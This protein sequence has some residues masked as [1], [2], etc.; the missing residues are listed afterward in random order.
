MFWTILIALNF[1]FSKIYADCIN[2]ES[3]KE[4]SVHRSIDLPDIEKE[5]IH[6]EKINYK[7]NSDA[8]Y[9]KR[10]TEMLDTIVLH[11]SATS[12]LTTPIEIN[13]HHINRTSND[14]AWYMTGYSYLINSPYQGNSTPAPKVSEGRP[15]DIVGSHAGSFA[16]L[17]MDSIQKKIWD[18]GLIICGT[19]SGPFTKDPTLVKDSK[20]KA[21]VTT[22]GVVVIGNYAP[23]SA[24]NPGGYDPKSPRLVSEETLDM[25][26]R[27]SCQI[28][29]QL[30][31]V[32]NLKWHSQFKQTSCPGDLVKQIEKI[33]TISKDYG[34][35]FF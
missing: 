29:K 31:R 7:K 27:L 12:T 30:P 10:P 1:N 20:I 14:Q 9:C 32:K 33:K 26:A 6:I 24:Y 2:C 13:N 4:Q 19:E 34:C 23:F 35:E 21:N 18:D 28:Q 16:F 5:L 22:I 8:S 15:L 17:Q 3:P 25:I 11:H